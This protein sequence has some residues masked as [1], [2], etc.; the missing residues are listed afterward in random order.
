MKRQLDDYYSKFYN[1]MATR[2]KEVSAN[3][4]AKAKE[5]A[6]WKEH[7]ASLWDK[8]NVVSFEV[9]GGDRQTSAI[10]GIQNTLSI[11]V[12]T[13]GLED[14]IGIEMVTIAT[15]NE[16]KEYVYNVAPFKL[17]GHSGNLSVYE[18]NHVIDNAGSF[19]VAYRIYPKND[20]L[21]HRQ[22]FCYVKWF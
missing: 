14:S 8:I 10:S 17:V 11:K 21:P 19:K 2:F 7:V 3:D 9:D 1:K 16:G 4:N 5:I 13:A 12:D 20:A 22:D 6:A 15:D 18:L